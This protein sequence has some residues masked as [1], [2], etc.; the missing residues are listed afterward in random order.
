M[1]SIAGCGDTFDAHYLSVNPFRT[2]V[3][4]HDLFVVPILQ[5]LAV[6]VGVLS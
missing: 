3:V 2:L 4:E 6:I 1:L 5:A